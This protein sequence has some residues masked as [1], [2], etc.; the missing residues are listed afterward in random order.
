MGQESAENKV[1][2]AY[3]AGFV[4]R[5]HTHPRFARFGQTDGHHAWGCAALIVAL[6]PCP[7]AVLLRAAITH[8]MGE[9]FA[10]DLSGP[11]KRAHPEVARAHYKAENEVLA[12]R[13]I[14]ASYDLNELDAAWLGY[15]DKL[16]C[17]LYA[18][19]TVPD[20]LKSAGWLRLIE[21]TVK[22]ADDLSPAPVADT[23]CL[24]VRARQ[25]CGFVED[26][27]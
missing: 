27:V 11:F 23:L 14:R 25:R 13:Y 9:R 18:S 8:D 24:I 16:E 20:A 4:Q 15:V 12:S 19:L 2:N 3:E 17:I 6:H 22:R 26:Y 10:G 1:L 21:N 7:S 5:Y